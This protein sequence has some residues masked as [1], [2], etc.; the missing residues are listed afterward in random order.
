M[1]I[2]V[3]SDVICPW[4]GIGQRRLDA[5]LDAFPHRDDV[6]VVHR[7]FQLDPTFPAGTTRPVRDM[8]KAKYGMSEAQLQASSR[9]LEG[10]AEAEGLVPYRV[11]Q[12]DVGNTR[13]AHELLAFAQAR[14]R[15]AE[16]WD[17]LYRA[18]F[19][20]GRSIFDQASLVTLGEELGF[21]G[22]EIREAL[23]SGRYR[24]QVEADG[25]EAHALGA[26]GVP[27]FVIDRRFGISGAQPREVFTQALQQAW[28]QRPEALSTTD[29]AVC[30]DDGCEVEH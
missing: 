2:E 16:A 25:A 14:G 27:F 21:E 20:Q 26:R 19:G 6:E 22:A 10:L 3:W 1:K 30:G 13:L 4:C 28:A 5:A 29:G 11:G 9:H 8:L 7:S 17:H 15:A 24:A 12:N 18:Y 23:D